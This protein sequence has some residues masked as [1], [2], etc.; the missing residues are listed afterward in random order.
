MGLLVMPVNPAEGKQPA[1]SL[2]LLRISGNSC[3]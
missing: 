3:R 1:S 2:S